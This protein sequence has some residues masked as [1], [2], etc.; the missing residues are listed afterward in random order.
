MV[1]KPSDE[2]ECRYKLYLQYYLEMS[3][4][5]TGY[6]GLSGNNHIY[7]NYRIIY[8]RGIKVYRAEKINMVRSYWNNAVFGTFL[9]SIATTVLMVRDKIF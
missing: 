6:F 5:K 7:F 9:T 4:S 2:R 8:Y 1:G 3:W